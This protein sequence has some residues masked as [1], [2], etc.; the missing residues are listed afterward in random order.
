MVLRFLQLLNMPLA[1]YSEDGL[2]IPEMLTE[3]MFGHSEMSEAM[4]SAL[5]HVS[6]LRSSAPVRP[7]QPEKKPPMSRALPVS[8]SFTICA[9]LALV[10]PSQ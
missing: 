8:T 1:L 3:V 5:G 10:M 6:P 9:A 7:S 2:V 4:V